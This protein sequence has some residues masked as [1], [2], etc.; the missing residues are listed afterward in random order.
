MLDP[1]TI[2][3]LW[4]RPMGGFQSML[5]R[6]TLRDVFIRLFS[7]SPNG[8][9]SISADR[10]P[11]CGQR[12]FHFPAE[13]E[14]LLLGPAW[15]LL[16]YRNGGGASTCCHPQFK[17]RTARHHVPRSCAHSPARHPSHRRHFMAVLLHGPLLV[18]VHED[19]RK[20]EGR[21]SCQI[22][23]TGMYATP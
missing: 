15:R 12:V 14:A 21:E 11:A 22:T 2:R 4:R 13:T 18:R 19:A 9:R 7:G 23:H 3:K 20:P 17:Q 1:V 10:A 6:Y 5:S 16:A 8:A